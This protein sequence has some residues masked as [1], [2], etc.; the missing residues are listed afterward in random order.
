MK[1]MFTITKYF[2]NSLKRDIYTA[3]LAVN[4]I[5]IICSCLLMCSD[6]VLSQWFLSDVVLS[7]MCEIQF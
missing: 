2:N 6:S 3:Y 7:K 1:I 5:D 4:I